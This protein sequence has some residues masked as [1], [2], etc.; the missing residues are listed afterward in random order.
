MKEDRHGHASHLI[1]NRDLRQKL[2][3]RLT[4]QF[5]SRLDDKDQSYIVA[6]ASVLRSYLKGKF[7]S[8]DD[9]WP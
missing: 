6:A 7:K 1:I 8:A 4:R 9:P 3:N 5:G 2:A